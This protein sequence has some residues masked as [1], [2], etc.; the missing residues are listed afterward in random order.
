[1]SLHQETIK[2][3]IFWKNNIKIINKRVKKEYKIPSFLIYSDASTS[4]FASIYNEKGKANIYYESFSDKDKSHYST[5]REL[6]AILFSLNSSNNKFDE[7]K[8]IFWYTD[9][10]A[11]SLTTR[12]C[13]NKPKPLD[14]ALEIH[15]I[16]STRNIDLNV[17]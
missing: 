2:E 14:L 12:K 9:N 13:G 15:K 16:S 5:C 8:T 4:G 10:N 11:C 1:M 17:S 7:N 3:I 6:E